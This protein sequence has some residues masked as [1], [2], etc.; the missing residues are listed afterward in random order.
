MSTYDI[1]AYQPTPT[2]PWISA[3]AIATST[4]RAITGVEKLIQRFLLELMTETNSMYFAPT[5]GCSFLTSLRNGWVLAEA[6]VFSAFN[7]AI[8][9]VTDNLKVEESSND[10]DNE[11]FAG[12]ELT[13]IVLDNNVLHLKVIVRSLAEDFG[14]LT[15]PVSLIPTPQDIASSPD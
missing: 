11:R 1:A 4:G 8:I 15:Y 9:T 10:P 6:D 12:A 13:G 2:G 7:A 14:V 5:R 3:L